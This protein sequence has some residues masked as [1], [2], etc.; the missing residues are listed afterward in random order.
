MIFRRIL[1]AVFVSLLPVRSS[2]ASP[3]NENLIRV[4]WLGLKQVGADTNAA[5]LMKVWQLPQ[6]AALLA[7]TLDKLSRCPGHGATNA[8]G[9]AFRPL[10]DDL[11]TSE[12]FLEVD[13]STNSSLSAGGEGR[14]E[15]GRSLSPVTRH[16]SLFF[17]IRL[18][19]DRANLWQTN[20]AAA[21]AA[22]AGSGT[23]HRIECAC[24]GDWTLVGA[25]LDKN[26]LQ[27]DFATRIAA[28]DSRFLPPA[29]RHP[30]LSHPWLEADLNPALLVSSLSA[31]EADRGEV[32]KLFAINHQLS[33][34][35]SLHL[36]LSGDA[37]NVHTLGVINFSRPLATPLPPWQI[38]TNFIHGPLTSFA[39][40]RGVAPW[41]ATM[42]AWQKLQ[43]APAPDQ[44]YLWAQTGAP[45]QTFF[46]APLPAAGGQLA[47]LSLRLVQNVNP[48]L[49][50]NADGF[51]QWQGSPPGVVWHLFVI[52]PFLEPVQ[53]HR[54][55]FLLGGLY[56]LAVGDPRPPPAEFLRAVLGTPDLVYYQAEHTGPRLEDDLFITQMFQVIFQKNKLPPAAAAARWLKQ[57]EP[58][59]GDSATAVTR[60]GTRQLT[61]ARNSTTGLT[62]L[63]LNLL[64]DWLESPQFPRGLHTF[65]A[66]PDKQ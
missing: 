12:F 38:P 57:I 10:L 20:L 46:A 1:F 4:H 32:E 22:L 21:S 15:V 2:V 58:L 13:V 62:A 43:F 25:G 49:V 16:P 53:V 54:Q 36:S 56:P 64:A 9:A 40:V 29:T 5:Q 47:Q 66:P 51:F 52:A 45:Y 61:L 63:E 8:A 31:G 11:I 26:I 34:I 28:A 23:P 60:T 37:G 48:W 27:T 35:S 30:S 14:G 19:A 39:A 50:T 17:A 6:T 18:P 55:D 59:L 24:A 44:A 65:L 3:A 41:L 7:Q 33:T 42:P